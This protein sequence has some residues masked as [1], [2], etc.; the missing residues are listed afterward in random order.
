MSLFDDLQ[1][2]TA[3]ARAATDAAKKR[4]DIVA[5]KNLFLGRSGQL[6]NLMGRIKELPNA[7]KGAFGQAMNAAKNELTAAFETAAQKFAGA[8]K[9]LPDPTLPPKTRPLGTLH[10]LRQMRDRIAGIFGRLGF[11]VAGGPEMEDDFHNFQALNIPPDHPARDNAETF[12]LAGGGLLRSQTSSVQIRTMEKMR[13]PIR[14]LAPGSVYRP[15]AVDAT[16]HYHFHQI[17]GLAVDTRVT[18]ADLKSCLL[19]FAREMFGGA[20]QIRLRPSFFPFTEPSAEM[21][22]SCVFCGQAGCRICKNSGWI[23]VLGCGM[24]D[25][26]VFREVGYDPEKYRGFAFGIGL[27]RMV[28]LTAGVNDIRLLTDSDLRFLRQF[29]A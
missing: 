3:A 23:E 8:E 11:A 29:V 6:N 16:H 13:P 4:E 7:E 25:P 1:A 2:L 9:P 26:N 10:P 19:F 15:D 17:E 24:I 22:V 5:A 18:L 20:A 14:I 12:A 28:M 27:D 21:D